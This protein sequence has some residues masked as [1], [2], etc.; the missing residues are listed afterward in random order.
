MQEVSAMAEASKSGMPSR[1]KSTP[2]GGEEACVPRKRKSTGMRQKKG[3]EES[4]GGKGGTPSTG[5]SA[6]RMEEE[7]Q[8]TVT[9]WWLTLELG[10]GPRS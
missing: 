5:K 1:G 3:V 8:G 7:C 10:N 2:M 4:G 9:Q 6:A